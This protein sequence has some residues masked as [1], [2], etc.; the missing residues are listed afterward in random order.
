MEAHADTHSSDMTPDRALAVYG[1]LAPGESNHHVL[2]GVD[3][4][5]RDGYIR[6]Y[7]FDVTWGGAEGY[8]GVVL[9]TGGNLIPVRVLVSDQLDRHWDRLDRFEGPGYHRDFGRGSRR[10]NR[11]FTTKAS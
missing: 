6:G 8:P 7:L 5:W 11:V 1:T 9:D 4:E 10:C 3:G 2:L